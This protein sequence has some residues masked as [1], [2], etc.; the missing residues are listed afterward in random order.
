M[1]SLVR[2]FR[3]NFPHW[4]EE[5]VMTEAATSYLEGRHCRPEV[6][7]GFRQELID[8]LNRSIGIYSL[9]AVKDE[10]LMWSHYADEHRGYCLMFEASDTTPFFG[11]AQEVHYSEALPAITP[12]SDTDLEKA[13]K[14]MLTKYCGWSYEREWRI[15]DHESGAGLR[16]YPAA[17]LVGVIFGARMSPRDRAQ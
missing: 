4:P 11:A 2:M 9:S 16:D 7:E 17:L 1:D 13:A 5:T 12:Y 3:R 6:W 10:I 8:T 14:A 15:V